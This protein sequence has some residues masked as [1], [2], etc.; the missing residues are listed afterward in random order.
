MNNAKA[1]LY[2]LLCGAYFAFCFYMFPKLNSNV[3]IPSIP[4]L[5]IG[6]W[7]FGT[8][9]GLILTFLFGCIY[10]VLNQVYGADYLYFTDRITGLMLSITMVY[11]FGY[12]RISSKG[13]R[14]LNRE[15]DNR[16]HE[17]EAELEA[18][19]KQLIST[20]ETRRMAQGQELHDGM[21]Q[22]LTGIQLLS[23]SLAQQ[24]KTENHHLYASI[25]SFSNTCSKVHN[26]IRKIARTLFP[27]RIAQVGLAAALD[28]LAGCLTEIRPARIIFNDLSMPFVLPEKECLQLYRICQESC[29][30]L[31]DSCKAD[32]LEISTSPSRNSYSVRIIHNGLAPWNNH[33]SALT[34]LIQY[35]LKQAGGT[36]TISITIDNRKSITFNIPKSHNPI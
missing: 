30:H 16:V 22:Q 8:T 1:I 6:A 36:Q 23:S 25:S 13:I 35:R 10:F 26:H 12:L 21:G 32:L 31:I 9:R 33:T 20:A 7:L 17:R 24:L 3:V 29:I 15:L 27:I 34:G 28:E 4:L 14:S 5:A 11:L 19:T 2:S 18:L